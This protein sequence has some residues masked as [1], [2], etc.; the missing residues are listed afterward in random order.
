MARLSDN[1][2]QKEGE[3]DETV[4]KENLKNFRNKRKALYNVLEDYLVGKPWSPLVINYAYNNNILENA[5]IRDFVHYI[6]ITL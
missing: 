3:E 6:I 1:P 5:L 2:L 4:V